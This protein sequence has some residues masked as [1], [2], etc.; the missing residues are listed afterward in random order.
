MI[1]SD[2][3]LMFESDNTLQNKL[4]YFCKLGQTVLPI[5]QLIIFQIITI[6]NYVIWSNK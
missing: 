5:D 1:A 6:C 2:E 3:F 4:Q